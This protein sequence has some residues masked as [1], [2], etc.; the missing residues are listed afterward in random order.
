MILGL[1][2]RLRGSSGEVL[3]GHVRPHPGHVRPHPGREGPLMLCWCWSKR[4]SP[5]DFLV[6]HIED[7]VTSRPR[8]SSH[9]LLVL[10]DRT[11]SRQ[12]QP[13]LATS[14]HIPASRAHPHA[15]SQ[16]SPCLLV[17]L[18]ASRATPSQPPLRQPL[19]I[20]G[21]KVFYAPPRPK[22]S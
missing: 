3:P 20:V 17:L 15:T 16:P 18:S 7:Q 5:A 22:V 10:G 2:E 14:S 21:P 4:P 12:P 8:G 11:L 6:F 9:A 19:W 13:H 1:P